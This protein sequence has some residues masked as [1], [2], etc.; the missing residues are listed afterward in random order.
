M[1]TKIIPMSR[2]HYV[3]SLLCNYSISNL[4]TYPISTKF[5]VSNLYLKIYKFQSLQVSN[6]QKLRAFQYLFKIISLE[7]YLYKI[8]YSNYLSI[9]YIL[10]SSLSMKHNY[11]VSQSIK[12][13]YGN[14]RYVRTKEHRNIR[15]V[16][17]VTFII[18]PQPC[19]TKVRKY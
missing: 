12:V 19:N 2:F 10:K 16:F 14:N 17:H 7:N 13:G 15:M 9:N 11:R 5:H 1:L 4:Q 3:S 6:F 8:I 18:A